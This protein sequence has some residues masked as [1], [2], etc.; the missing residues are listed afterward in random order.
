MSADKSRL[1]R[2]CVVNTHYIHFSSLLGMA[3]VHS[4]GVLGGKAPG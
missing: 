1:A 2:M 4:D 3:I